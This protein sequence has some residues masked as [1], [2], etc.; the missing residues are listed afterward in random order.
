MIHK[1]GRPTRL[2][3]GT[4]ASGLYGGVGFAGPNPIVCRRFC[5]KLVSVVA[6]RYWSGGS[7]AARNMWAPIA[8]EVKG[9]WSGVV[10]PHKEGGVACGVT[11]RKESQEEGVN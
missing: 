2:V 3:E 1:S 5:S 4:W 9:A 7:V 8:I 10:Q 6:R 11:R